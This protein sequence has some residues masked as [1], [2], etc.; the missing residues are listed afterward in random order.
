MDSLLGKKLLYLSYSDVVSVGVTMAEIITALERMF[1]E[2]AERD[3]EMPPKIGIHSMPDAFIHAMPA[4]ISSE[5]VAGMKWVSGYPGNTKLGLPY[6]SGLLILND[7]ETGIPIA[8][9]DCTWITAQRT[10][11]ATAV[12]SGSKLRLSVL[13]GCCGGSTR[14]R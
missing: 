6:I 13:L 12:S 8:V 4:L 11:A 2:K 1:C 9:M 14:G 10:G 5:R 3:I 7:F